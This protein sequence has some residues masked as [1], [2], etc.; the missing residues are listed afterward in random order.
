MRLTSYLTES[1]KNLIL[2]TIGV[3]N[4]KINNKSGSKINKHLF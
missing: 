1:L 4:N 3:E 2:K